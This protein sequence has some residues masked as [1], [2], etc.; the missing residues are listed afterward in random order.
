[1]TAK[2]RSRA[3]FAAA[4]LI[5]VVAVAALTAVLRPGGADTAEP[6]VSQ[7]Y[8]PQPASPDVAAAYFTV[9]NTGGRPDTLKAV[10][11]DVS[12]MTMMHRTTANTMEAVPS[13]TVPAHGKLVFS[14]GGY[15]VMIESPVRGLRQGDRVRLTLTFERA[16]R[17]T[18]DAPV[19]PIGYR[20]GGAATP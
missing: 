5:A 6:R 20:P 15:H 10:S 17:I 18:V 12:G 4:V 13:L 1:M 11:S 9:T 7:A 2:T 3:P 19:M 14:P 16:G 8:V